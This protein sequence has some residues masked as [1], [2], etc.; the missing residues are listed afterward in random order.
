M[1]KARRWKAWMNI[2]PSGIF[3]IYRT[4]EDA[5]KC[6]SIG[7]KIVRVEVRELPRKGARRARCNAARAVLARVEGRK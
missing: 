3:Y 1:K 4:K 7:G 5:G 6:V 2:Y